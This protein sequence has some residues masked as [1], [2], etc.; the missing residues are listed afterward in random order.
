MLEKQPVTI[1]KRELKIPGLLKE[2]SDILELVSRKKGEA[3]ILLELTTSK[4]L[5]NP[6]EGKSPSKA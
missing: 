4:L 6:E 5:G 2:D 1:Q 3:N